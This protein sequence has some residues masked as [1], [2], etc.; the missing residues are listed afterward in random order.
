MGLSPRVCSQLR[1]E[2]PGLYVLDSGS[3][4]YIG[5]GKSIDV[6]RWLHERGY[7][8]LGLEG[9]KADGRS[10][11]PSVDHIA[12]FTDLGGQSGQVSKA[13]RAAVNILRQWE[14]ETVEFVD[15]VVE[16]PDSKSGSPDVNVGHSVA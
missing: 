10:I 4:T 8:I 9:V 2:I 7:A 5:I 11:I 16:E 1:V 3:T 12:D 6:A 15:F 13:L 14:A